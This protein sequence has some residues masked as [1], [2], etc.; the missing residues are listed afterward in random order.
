MLKI[1]IFKME[2]KKM[3][4]ILALLL[5]FCMVLSLGLMSASADNAIE[6]IK[7]NFATANASAN[8]ESVFAERFIELCG[9][10]SNGAITFDYTDGGILGTQLELVEGT[11]YHV[12]DMT[13]TS[14]DNLQSWIPAISVASYPCLIDSYET[15]EK[16][17]DGEFGE[18]IKQMSHEQVG[19]DLLNFEWCGFRNIC[20]EKEIKN[21]ADAKNVLIRVPE[22]QT[23]IDLV[24]LMGFS[25]VTMSWS[26]AYTSMN[27]G[28]INA[29]EVPLQN[30]YEQGF[31]DLG[32]YVLMSRHIFNTNTIMANSDFMANL[33]EATRAII[34]EAIK[35]ATEEERIEC[36]AR[37]QRY[38][39]SL[40]EVGVTINEWDE[41]SYNELQ[42]K[43][44]NYWETSASAIGDQA[45]EFLNM[46]KAAK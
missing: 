8:I 23:Y 21:L 22:V 24:T 19:I 17:F 41:D 28:I 7:I 46:I 31:Y 38:I 5:A 9:E 42:A 43:F 3:R 45:I 15:G 26:E 34:E 2:D 1:K 12:Y 40:K 35:Q 20:S 18:T 4:K 33:P 16:V 25:P 36:Q 39:D 14:V 27:S 10:L 44:A 29:V 11:M 32:K 30:I 13:C 6:P 37:E